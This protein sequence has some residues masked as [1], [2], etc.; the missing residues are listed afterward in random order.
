MTHK[1]VH[2]TKDGQPYI[3]AETSEIGVEVLDAI[4][5]RNA[6]K[7]REKELEEMRR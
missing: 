4:L 2:L 7:K 6:V 5:E 3:T 1:K